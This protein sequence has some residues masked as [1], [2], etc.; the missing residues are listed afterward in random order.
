MLDGGLLV[1]HGGLLV[2]HGAAGCEREMKKGTSC[3][4]SVLRITKLS[5][6][7]CIFCS[8]AK[9]SGWRM[10]QTYRLV[11]LYGL[12]GISAKWLNSVCQLFLLQGVLLHPLIV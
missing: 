5:L 3:L 12:M 10:A 6:C 2:Q 8:Y 7:G 1:Q 4:R 11:Q 9:G